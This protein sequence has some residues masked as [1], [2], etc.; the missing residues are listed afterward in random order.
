M[1]T[2]KYCKKDDSLINKITIFI[3]S[4]RIHTGV[5]QRVPG[6]LYIYVDTDKYF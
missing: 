3:K 4:N 1:H 2:S 6:W 5:V